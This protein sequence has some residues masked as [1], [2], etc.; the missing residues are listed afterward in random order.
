MFNFKHNRLAIDSDYDMLYRSAPV[1]SI[2]LV[3]DCV[4]IFDASGNTEPPDHYD[5]LIAFM[6]QYDWPYIILTSDPTLNQ[7]KL[8]Y[9]PQ[10]LKTIRQASRFN[11]DIA[12]PRPYK[13]C[14]L[15][16]NSHAH[17]IWL[18]FNLL[19]KLDSCWLTYHNCPGDPV[20]LAELD[21]DLIKLAAEL[22]VT[23]ATTTHLDNRHPAYS[24][25]YVDICTETMMRRDVV[26]IGEKTWKPI[27]SGQLFLIAG[28]PG[29]IQQLRNW[30]LDVYDDIID[31]SYDEPGTWQER[32]A[33]FAD[34]VR[35]LQN[36]DLDAVWAQTVSRRAANRDL[37][38]SQVIEKFYIDQTNAR[39]KLYYPDLCPL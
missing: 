6:D 16:G 33:K 13:F 2:G 23:R 19:N 8:C 37:V 26:I 1:D 15:N 12:S 5:R 7:G 28:G 30:G 10:F 22:P 35:K 27:V 32:I 36:L 25:A 24:Q 17:R 31:H 29:T 20:E 39:V 38:A 11:L 14:S 34:S 3:H 9:H 4:N 21:P 18:Y